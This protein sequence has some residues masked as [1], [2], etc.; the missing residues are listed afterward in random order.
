MTLSSPS[1]TPP[2]SQLALGLRTPDAC[3]GGVGGMGCPILVLLPHSLPPR[4][5]VSSHSP[6]S[7]PVLTS[8][9][10]PGET[11]TLVQSRSWLL[12]LQPC[13]PHS[14][15]GPPSAPLP[16]EAPYS[17]SSGP[18]R[19]SRPVLAD[20]LAE[21]RA[22]MGAR[23]RAGSPCQACQRPHLC[24]RTTFS[25]VTGR[26]WLCPLLLFLVLLPCLPERLFFSRSWIF[27]AAYKHARFLPS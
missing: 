21:Q 15:C 17:P 22:A 16:L 23:T 10:S 3:G 11:L 13:R 7:G 25:A 1:Y 9:H 26:P 6:D 8:S 2:G 19:C 12:C 18:P 14:P 20:D 5:S 27:P 4:P 24:P